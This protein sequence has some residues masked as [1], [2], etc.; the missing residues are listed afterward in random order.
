MKERELTIGQY[1][2]KAQ[3]DGMREIYKMIDKSFGMKK[4]TK[5]KGY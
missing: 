3:S 1:V 4:K 2:L 5:K